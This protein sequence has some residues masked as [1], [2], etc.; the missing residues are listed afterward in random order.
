MRP[1]AERVAVGTGEAQRPEAS[2]AA[3]SSAGMEAGEVVGM[4]ADGELIG[5]E[6]ALAVRAAVGLHRAFDPPED[7]DRL[8]PGPEQARAGAFDE[9]LEEALHA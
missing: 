7:L 3:T 6:A 8:E 4:Q 2:S 1:L 5:H 9:P